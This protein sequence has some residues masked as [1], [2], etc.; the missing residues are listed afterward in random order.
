MKRLPAVQ[1]HQ[2]K[3]VDQLFHQS[4]CLPVRQTIG[5]LSDQHLGVSNAADQSFSFKPWPVGQ[6]SQAN[7]QVKRVDQEFHQR[8]CLPVRKAINQPPEVCQNHQIKI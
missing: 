8:R 6:K 3:R 2:V 1:N 7:Q 4:R 5:Q